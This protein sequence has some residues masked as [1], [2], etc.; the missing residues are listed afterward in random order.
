MMTIPHENH[1]FQSSKRPKIDQEASQ[2][3]FEVYK[4]VRTLPSASEKMKKNVARVSALFCSQILHMHV[5]PHA[6]QLLYIPGMIEPP[7]YIYLLI[8]VAGPG[9]R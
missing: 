9:W 8:L 4:N 5:M 1:I 2:K 7:V 6:G 3:R